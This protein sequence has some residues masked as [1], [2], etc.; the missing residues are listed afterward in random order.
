MCVVKL[1]MEFTVVCGV[2]GEPIAE[3]WK[4]RL[5]SGS[6]VLNTTCV[7]WL[8]SERNRPPDSV[9]PTEITDHADRYQEPIPQFSCLYNLWGGI[10]V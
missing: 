5:S 6:L 8:I 10:R 9:C 3:D 4:M 7:A 1:A 2:V